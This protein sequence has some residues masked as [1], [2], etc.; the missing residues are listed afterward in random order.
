[1]GDGEKRRKEEGKKLE[2]QFRGNEGRQ[3]QQQQ[4]AVKP[5]LRSLFFYHLNFQFYMIP[6]YACLFSSPYNESQEIAKLE[7]II[8]AHTIVYVL[9]VCLK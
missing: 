8:H 3:Q 6:L 5:T 4:N 7:N 2:L 1:M 9:Y